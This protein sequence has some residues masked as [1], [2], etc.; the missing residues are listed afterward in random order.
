MSPVGPEVTSQARDAEHRL[1]RQPG[2]RAL[3][4][5]VHEE[6]GDGEFTEVAVSER[7]VL[8]P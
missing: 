3:G 4:D 7:F 5:A 1:A 2:V 8:L 6:V